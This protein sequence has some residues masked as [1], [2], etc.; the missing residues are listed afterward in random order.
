MDLLSLDLPDIE[1]PLL[2]PPEKLFGF[3]YVSFFIE[4][5][6]LAK[7]TPAAAAAGGGGASSG[8]SFGAT[9]KG[10]GFSLSS[11]FSRR[12]SEK[13]I[14][15]S[16]PGGR[17]DKAAGDGSSAGAVH[18]GATITAAAAAVAAAARAA[19]NHF[20]IRISVYNVK[21]NLT[22]AQ[23]VQHTYTRSAQTKERQIYVCEP[24]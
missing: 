12:A 13:N 17:V 21:G 9:G 6:T 5:T 3:T 18:Q 10:G 1:N 15:T 20:F 4:K 19:D 11:T 23:Q 7:A 2:P 8:S 16:N 14:D 24:L 22:E